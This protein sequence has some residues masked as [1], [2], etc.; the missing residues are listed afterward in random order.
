[1]RAIVH[2]ARTFNRKAE[3]IHPTCRSRF[4]LK[5]IVP[6]TTRGR[7]NY[8]QTGEDADSELCVLLIEIKQNVNVNFGFFIFQS[9]ISRVDYYSNLN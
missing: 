6:T 9:V 7:Y 3:D 8:F 5:A 2:T 1:M 4:F